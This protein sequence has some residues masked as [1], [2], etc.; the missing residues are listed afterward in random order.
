MEESVTDHKDDVGNTQF[1]EQLQHVM[2]EEMTRQGELNSLE[3]AY[4][5]LYG[6]DCPRKLK[7]RTC[8]KLFENEEKLKKHNTSQLKR[9]IVKLKNKYL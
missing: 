9:F 5:L 8:G 7:C 4:N 1:D 2:D 3:Y 6:A